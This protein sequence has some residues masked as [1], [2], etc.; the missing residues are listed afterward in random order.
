[1]EYMEN[2]KSNDLGEYSTESNH[3][4]YTGYETLL[5]MTLGEI[6]IKWH[7]PKC[8]IFSPHLVSSCE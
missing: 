2:L 4:N 5:K 1:M 3:C 8:I 6:E 7:Q